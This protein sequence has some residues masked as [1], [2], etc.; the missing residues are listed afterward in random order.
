[1]ALRL[2]RGKD[3]RLT[4]YAP[5]AGGVVRWTEDRPGGPTW[6]GPWLIEAPGLSGVTVA[7]G[8]DGYAHLVGVRRRTG[9]DGAQVDIVHATQFQTG[10]PLTAWHSLGT[11]TPRTAPR[12]SGPGRRPRPWTPRARCMSSFATPGAG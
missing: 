7:Q 5:V 2:L 8:A 4:A 1:M 9:K 10:R 12:R 11:R 3:G 6:T